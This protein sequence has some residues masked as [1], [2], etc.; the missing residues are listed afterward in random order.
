MKTKTEMIRNTEISL[1]IDQVIHVLSE[2]TRN[3]P[4]VGLSPE[5]HDIFQSFVVPSA[6][7]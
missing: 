1:K 4:Y 5:T 3:S 6:K 2:S 7:T